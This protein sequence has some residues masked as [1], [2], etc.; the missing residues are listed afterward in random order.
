M[1]KAVCG[2][3]LGCLLWGCSP[4]P[5]RHST[6]GIVREIAQDGHA[7]TIAHRDFPGFME[8]MTM[9]FDVPDQKLTRGL[10]PGDT[11]EFTITRNG[12][13]WPVSELAKTR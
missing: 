9:T 1:R 3:I 8:A 12:D 4:K 5:E 11:V 2:I 6:T 10:K 7:V 13:A